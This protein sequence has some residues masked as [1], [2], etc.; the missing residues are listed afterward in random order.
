MKIP[1]HFHILLQLSH[2]FLCSTVKFSFLFNNFQT[3][4]VCGRPRSLKLLIV[5]R[6]LR[7]QQTAA[8]SGP[9]VLSFRLLSVLHAELTMLSLIQ[10][11]NIKWQTDRQTVVWHTIQSISVVFLTKWYHIVFHWLYLIF[12]LCSSFILGLVLHIMK[13]H[14]FQQFPLAFHLIGVA[15]RRVNCSCDT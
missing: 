1:I 10:S 14:P 15:V 8:G 11:G 7:Q 5:L 3:P 13:Y 9:A 6:L 12:F 4:V 2:L